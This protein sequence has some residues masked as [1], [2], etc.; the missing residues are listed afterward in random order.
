[1]KKLFLPV[2]LLAGCAGWQESASAKL[3]YIHQASQ[4][5]V[6]AAIPIIDGMCRNAA[7]DCAER[8]DESC[9]ALYKCDNYRRQFAFSVIALYQT[10][11]AADAALAV[12]DEEEA[13]RAINQAITQMENLRQVM[14]D[15]GLRR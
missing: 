6:S 9:P 11:V 10:L 4:S 13:W 8:D 12:G 15:L 2:L 5:V 7:I 14:K 1:M 3:E